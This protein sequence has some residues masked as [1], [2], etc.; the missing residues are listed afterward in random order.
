[1]RKI[2]VLSLFIISV[3]FVASPSFAQ[4]QFIQN[5]GQWD[6]A[7]Q[8]KGDISAGAFFLENKGFS[9][10]LNNNDDLNTLSETFHG[11]KQTTGVSPN[12]KAVPV[13]NAMPV[14]TVHSHLYRVKFLNASDAINI[15][16]DKVQ[17]TYNNYFIGNDKSK[18]ASDCKIYAAVTY[19]NVYPNIDVRYYSASGRL[20]Y[21]IIVNPGGDPEQIAMLYEGADK[22]EVKNK[23]LVIGTS[24]GEVKELYPYSYQV[25]EG[26]R[27]TLECKYVVKNNV[28]RFK[29]TGRDENSTLVI[30]PTLK[31]ASFTG[32]VADNWGYTATPGPD[33]SFYAG[34]I[35]FGNGY[36]VS[37]GAFQTN[38]GGGVQED[39]SGAYDIALMK[40]S[41]NGVNRIYATYLGGT[42][43]EQPHSLIC[44]PQGNLIVAGRSNSPNYPLFP[45]G[46]SVGPNGAYDI[47]VTKFNAAGNG[48]IGSI[49]VGGSGDDGVNI[50][51][52]YSLPNNFQATDNTR[53][54]YGDD[55]RSEVILD[56]AGNAYLATCTQSNNFPVLNSTI[57]TS[58]AGGKQDGAILKFTPN[59]SAVTFSTYFGGSGDDACYVLSLSPTT[60]KL[61][62][63]G[64]TTSN[65]LPGNT[66][67][68][69][70]STFQG[71]TVDGFVTELE[72]DGSALLKTTYAGTNG[73]D[74]VYGLKFDKFGFPY[75]MGT[76]TG[77]WP[78]LNAVYSNP[79]S[80][81]FIAKLQPDLS[82][83]VYSTV[84]G[85]SSSL[86]NISP[87]AF[88]VD[89]CENVY[90]SGW[91]GGINSDL[92]YPCGNTTGVPIKGQLP[93]LP[94]PDG[95][96][97]YF[98]VLEKNAASQFFGSTYGQYGGVGDHV[99]GGTSR[100]DDNGIIYQAMCA[101]C[102]GLPPPPYPY[103][104]FPTTPG[105]WATD[106]GSSNCN[107]A[108]VKIEMNFAGVGAGAEARI[109]GVA[110]TSGC[111]SLYVQ[112]RD[113]LQKGKIFVWDFGDGSPKV[114]LIG[115]SDTAHTYPNPGYYRV[116]LVA[117]DSATCNIADT[118][119][120]TIKAGNNVAALNFISNKIPPCTNLQYQYTNVSTATFTGF[121]AQSFIWDYG[122]GS[123]R[124]TVGLNPPRQ[125]TYASAGTY[126]VTLVVDDT[127]FCNSPDSITKTIRINPLVRAQFNTPA[128]GCVPHTA[129]FDN[130]SL[131]GTDFFWDFGD[132]NFSTD[133]NP[134][135]IYTA[136]G[137]YHVVMIATDT[138][139]CNK[140][141]TARFTIQV[142]A[143][144]TAG[145]TWGPQPVRENTPTQ[146]NNQSIGAT[147][148]LWQFGDGDTS[149]DVNPIHQFNTTATFTTCLMASNVAGCVDTFCV[150]V[151]ARVLS[152]LDVPNAFTPGR[153]GQNGIVKVAGFGI[154]KME[155]KIYNRWGQMV[156]STT[157]RNQGWDGTFKGA[158]QP[159]DVYTYTLD[160]VFTDGKKERKTGDITLLR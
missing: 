22:L 107:E 4:M 114:T 127:L 153:D 125:H 50:R 10:L 66:S 84:F 85:T 115:S 118:A 104:N 150:D 39:A 106:N 55:A 23:E 46:N 47:V 157:N 77:D 71:A 135:H 124:D 122:D 44:D 70:Y 48:L 95:K 139:T 1:M 159:L 138:G 146:F 128:R 28:V 62:V 100:F 40:L 45:A 82:A 111:T 103:P 67:G 147:A 94:P 79:G 34:G 64:G 88:L 152:L 36:K 145:F 16:P 113:T 30:D 53:R 120:L 5:K 69:V 87:I 142:F 35:A 33:G 61:Y 6:K 134:V 98:F 92:Q 133:P 91:G 126:K 75:I 11:H 65:N 49:R 9:V 119:Y 29:I 136:V 2:I 156:F 99:D 105:V 83:F 154:G 96:D 20:K 63:G 31:F 78:V 140:T 51:T 8:Y 26:K 72:P 130:T 18:W 17:Q 155:W 108:C 129:V 25:N 101:N 12:T 68:S 149:V 24:V 112:F 141:D 90:V 148:Y 59:L 38:F 15:Q 58:F 132:N 74:Q 60:G 158:L 116:M 89:R 93:N 151:P 52:K 37:F 97:F 41:P 144:P 143:I 121:R 19:K 81:Q 27:Q 57:Q 42:G 32:S 7:V 80:K 54:N 3:L 137:I 13:V 86:P 43:N 76:T 102:G 73:N 131:A 56:G 117:I 160:V 109:N 110:D 21:D 14:V 123:K